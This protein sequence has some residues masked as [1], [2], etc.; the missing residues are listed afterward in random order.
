MTRVV[1][2]N[3][4][5]SESEECCVPVKFSMY[6]RND[7]HCSENLELCKCKH[8]SELLSFEADWQEEIKMDKAVV[9][10]PKTMP[11]L[12]LSGLNVLP[13]C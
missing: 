9:S 5:I 11:L 10:V 6:C 8:C 12:C 13:Y 3:R 2:K 1:G 7:L 4:G